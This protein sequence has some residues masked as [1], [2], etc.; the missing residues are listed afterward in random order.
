MN[1]ILPEIVTLKAESAV[2]I[3]Y[4][5]HPIAEVNDHVVRIATM[6][7]PYYWHFIPTPTRLSSWLKGNSRLN[8]REDP[9][10]LAL[11]K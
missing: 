6:S 8:S 11:A 9:G 7:E 2:Q 3:G 10:S 1:R 4:D 5:N